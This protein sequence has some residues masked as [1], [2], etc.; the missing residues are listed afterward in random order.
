VLAKFDKFP[1]EHFAWGQAL[2]YY[3][4][5]NTVTKDRILGKAWEAQLT[6]LVT[7]K[8]CW[9]GFVKKW[10]LQNQPQEVVGF[11]PPAQSPLETTLQLATTHAL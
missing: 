9:A 4:C 6:M 5:V 11:L 10:L 1:I 7:R 8:K 2:L 3:N